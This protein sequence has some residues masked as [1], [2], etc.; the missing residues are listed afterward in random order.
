MS[1]DI[2]AVKE[3]QITKE[4]KRE[5]NYGGIA[6]VLATGQLLRNY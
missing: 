2:Y 6:T 3:E 1:W 5:R 4:R